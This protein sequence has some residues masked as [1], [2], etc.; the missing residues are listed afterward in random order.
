MR[1][2]AHDGD[3]APVLIVTHKITRAALDEALLAM[4]G[5][6]VMTARPVAIRIED[7]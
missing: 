1:Q 3:A 7:I 2:Y 4:D 5:T 6:G